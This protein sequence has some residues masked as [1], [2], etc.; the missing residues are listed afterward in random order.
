MRKDNSFKYLL[1]SLFQ[2]LSPIRKRQMIIIMLVIFFS[3]LF[4]IVSLG[5]FLPFLEVL[6]NQKDSVFLMKLQPTLKSFN[7]ILNDELL[8]VT[9]IFVSSVTFS[10]GLRMLLLLLTSKFSYNISSDF[11]IDIYRKTLYQ[12]FL[13]H[14]E[15]NSSE[16]ISGILTKAKGIGSGI[17]FPLINALNSIILIIFVV[18][19]IANLNF[20]I[21]LSTFLSFSIVYFLISFYS[22]KKIAVISDILSIEQTKVHKS[23]VEGLGGI[24]DVILDGS[25]E[26]YL[27]IFALS[28]TKLRNASASLSIYGSLPRYVIEML[29]MAILAICAYFVV[30]LSDNL[31]SSIPILGAIGFGAQ[32]LLPSIHSLYSSWVTINSQRLTL[33]DTLS[34]LNEGKILEIDLENNKK[35]IKFEK[36]IIVKSLTFSF[37]SELPPVLNGINFEILKGQKIGIIGETGSGKSTLIDILMGLLV[38]SRG[39]IL[40]DGVLLEKKN[41]RYWQNNISHV[42]QSIFLA[43]TTI[44]DNICLGVSGEMVDMERVIKSAKSAQLFDYISSLPLKFDTV[45][46]EKGVRL[47]GG[48]RQRIGIARALYKESSVIVFDEATSS[49]DL[50]TE[51]AVMNAIYSLDPNLTLIIVAHRLTTLKDCDKIIEIK[52]GKISRIFKYEELINQI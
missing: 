30:T 25:Q 34:L 13:V 20:W 47:S 31:S 46:G 17:L 40:L 36:S 39:E 28:D 21:F 43:D 12:P 23:L 33:Q 15:R 19:F 49:L 9:I 52:N 37:K 5:A 22:K 48:Q 8:L 7:L 2:L 44:R 27:D 16:V 6:T 11:S 26:F 18:S 50:S 32:R 24:R 14:I 35:K 1:L 45:V 38:A 42:P 3:S 29:A 41:I 10:G 4:E 51:E